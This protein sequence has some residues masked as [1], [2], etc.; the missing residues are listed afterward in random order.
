MGSPRQ[1]IRQ[2]FPINSPVTQQMAPPAVAAADQAP[3]PAP[4]PPD[5][6]LHHLP[7]TENRLFGRDAE[8][9]LIEQYWG[10]GTRLLSIV[11]EGGVGKTALVWG[12]L[13]SLAM[14]GYDG[15]RVFA[16]STYL[17]GTEEQ[18]SADLFFNEALRRFGHDGEPP[19]S[20]SERGALLARKVRERRTL[21]VLDGLEPL[22]FPPGASEGRI[23]DPAMDALIK[24][25]AADNP[26]LC[27]VTTRQA[28][29]DLPTA[30]HI[31]LTRLTP[32]AGA[33]VLAAA[34]VDGSD[35]ERQ[36]VAVKFDG[37]A[38]ALTLLGTW[39]RK[40]RGG[41]LRCHGEVPLLHDDTRPGRHARRVMTAYEKWLQPP[42]L[43]I[44][45]LL[46]LFDRPVKPDLIDVVREAGVLPDLPA[47]DAWRIALTEL[48]DARLL[49]ADPGRTGALDAHPLVRAHFAERFRQRD[50]EAWRR[51][52]ARLYEHL[53]DTTPD[54]PDTLAGLEPLYQALAHGCKAGLHQQAIDAVYWPRIRRKRKHFSL[55]A[56]GAFGAE[57]AALAGFFDPPWTTPVASVTL[58][59][60]AWL[61]NEAGVTLRAVGRLDEAVAAFSA[62]LDMRVEQANWTQAAITAANLCDTH[63]LRGVVTNAVATARLG[64]AFADRGDDDF[65]QLYTRTILANA[66]AQA[67]D[68]AGAGPLFAEAE[69]RQAERQPH[70][71]RLYSA[72]GFRYCDLLLDR[73]A[74]AEVRERAAAALAVAR[75]AEWALDIALGTL[76]LGRAEALAVRQGGGDATLAAQRLDQ[77]IAALRQ[78]GQ[79]QFEVPGFLARAGFR[80]ERGELDEARCDL[81]EARR[82]AERGGMRLY[83]ADIALEDARLALAAGHRADART[84]LQTAQGLIAETGYHRRD[85]DAREIAEQLQVVPA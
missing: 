62:G 66:L 60:Q 31:D 26:G 75:S 76:S 19:P 11:A 59:W 45:G 22:Q 40:A 68:A 56:L 67:D 51:A 38:L 3:P 39:L 1:G 47:G 23:R 42:H 52:H 21:L 63:L 9:A 71:P 78:A 53:R 58:G 28:L 57:L 14:R 18:A 44:L 81:D 15:V 7:A 24:D 36:A 80:R 35:A 34:G 16:W 43:A 84:H 5:V 85:R 25:L 79:Q 4:A 55:K 70:L 54:F 69:R 41:D 73:G 27:L 13:D 49:A 30:P 65:Q 33:Q 37:H 29:S 82:M 74:V 46:G 12:W 72:Q 2:W 48:R 77:A 64:V 10:N 83:L 32:E 61:L 50:P 20:P 6:C 8:L 17:Q